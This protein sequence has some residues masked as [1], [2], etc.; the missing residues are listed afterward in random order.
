VHV[1][2]ATQHLADVGGSETYLYT[3]A[4]NLVRLGHE[5]TVHAQLIGAMAEQVRGVGATVVD[6]AGLPETC[7]AVL[8]QDVGMAYAMADRWPGHPQV[9]VAHSAYFDLQLPPLVPVPGSAVVVMSDRVGARVAALPGAFEVVR[10][11]QPIDAVRLAPRG[12]VADR[13]RR[14]VLL[15]NYLGGEARD[16]IVESWSAAKVEVVQVGVMTRPTLDVAAAVADADIVV[17]KGRAVLDAMACG[18]P[19]FLYDAF[20][21]DGWV[22]AA[23]YDAFEADA[24]AGQSQPAVLDRDGLARALEGY[25]PAMG[26]VN[27]E[28]V[29]KHHQDRKHAEALVGIF[30]RLTPGR[31]DRPTEA[32][33]LARLSRLRWKAE[34]EAEALRRQ[35]GDLTG[36]LQAAEE[37]L[38]L[39]EQRRRRRA[40]AARRAEQRLAELEEGKHGAVDAAQ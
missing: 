13:P 31:D 26:R 22:T 36:R 34:L 2:L 7:D 37:K 5:V 9:H 32:A 25:D 21:A 14:A 39:S 4:E 12:T 27:R 19:A 8:V 11:R 40:R 16:A 23:T 18:R 35:V 28:L 30:R 20:G 33:E 15:G 29:L 1:V 3:V 24:F 17:G 6:E 38:H 10:L